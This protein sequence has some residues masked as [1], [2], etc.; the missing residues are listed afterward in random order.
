MPAVGW[1]PQDGSHSACTRFDPVAR[2]HPGG[3]RACARPVP[4]TR[5]NA[6]SRGWH[7]PRLAR[8]ITIPASERV[9][10]ER[11]SCT[12]PAIVTA[13]RRRVSELANPRRGSWSPPRRR[14]SPGPV[15]RCSS[16]SCWRSCPA[17]ALACGESRRSRCAMAG[18]PRFRL[19]FDCTMGVLLATSAGHCRRN[20]RME[21]R[22]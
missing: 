1:S 21:T 5:R 11:N 17:F 8:C 6:E 2:G 15:A 19:W 10:R 9:S 22:T 14:P 20:A 3:C 18:R 13:R 4:A 12:R 7:L 16:H